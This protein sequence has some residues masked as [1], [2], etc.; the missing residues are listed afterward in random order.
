M[1]F[2]LTEKAKIPP[3]IQSIFKTMHE[4]TFVPVRTENKTSPKFQVCIVVKQGC[5]LAPALFLTYIHAITQITLDRCNA[6]VEIRFRNDLDMFSRRNLKAASKTEKRKI[7]E[8]MFADD[9]ALIAETLENLQQLLD[10]F[11]EVAN[12]FG[13]KVNVEKTKCMFINC[14]TNNIHIE[15]AALET[16][17]VF[18]YLGNN[19]T[20]DGSCNKEINHRISAAARAFG[21]LYHRVWKSHD[22]SM[23]TK[24]RI[25]ETVVLSTLLY[26]TETLTLLE[27]HKMKLN[28]T[29]YLGGVVIALGEL[30][31]GKR[32]P[33]KPRK[34]W[35]DIVK[36]DLK[37]LSI[38]IKEWRELAADRIAWREETKTKILLLHQQNLEQ[39]AE[40]RTQ[41]HEEEDTYSWK[42]PLCDFKCDGRRGREYVN[43]HLTQAH[44]TR[45]PPTTETTRPTVIHCTICDLQCKSKSGLTSHMRH[46][47]PDAALASSIPKPIRL[48][49]D[50]RPPDTQQSQ[51]DQPTSAVP[52]P[53]NQWSCPHF[54]RSFRSKAGLSSHTRSN[55]C[56]VQR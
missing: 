19:I 35:T 18:K 28:A 8:L 53:S 48:Q 6:G 16:V 12:Q 42:C 41:R 44:K 5:V 27:K 50:S 23:K 22:L 39:R 32:N 11:V 7:Q 14:S 56:G 1:L 55:K 21:S 37:L 13:L 24:I 46:K 34:R 43:S 54:Q 49:S 31:K 4:E 15:G 51:H 3:G 40:R 17:D 10:T 45:Q 2:K 25:H 20:P 52:I 36:D 26:S 30:D 47:H 9:A 29:T 33:C 38:N